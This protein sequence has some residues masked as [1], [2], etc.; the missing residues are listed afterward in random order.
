MWDLLPSD[1]ERM[2]AAAV[3]EYLEGELPLARLRPGAGPGDPAKA[4]QGMA[5]LGWFGVGLPE[6]VGGAGLGLVA[7]M[8]IQRECGRYLVSPTVL[9]TV[10]ASHVAFH[11]GDS[12]R[13]A[14][15]VAGK[16]PMALA[17][18]AEPA[19]QG[20][21]RE[22]TAFDWNAGEPLL[23]WNEDGMGLFEAGAF[24]TAEAGD[25]FDESISLHA[26]RLAPDEASLW[27]PAD[28]Q[29][30]LLRAQVLLAAAL[31]GLAEHACDLAVDY[32]RVREQFGKPIG[33]FQAI[34]QRCADM[35]V[36]QRLSWY[37]T[38]LA[39]LKLESAAA[40]TALQVASAKLLAAEAAHENG[41]A[42]IQVHGGIG[43]QA[44]CDAQWFLM[45]ARLFDQAGGA[46]AQQA[47]RIIAAPAP[48]W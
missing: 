21:K 14:E 4:W 12:A 23:Y 36:R 44:E 17:I 34:K 37:Q 40:D 45:R 15:L 28:V 31:V 24:G 6:A 5:E 48:A 18:D 41:R 19:R 46:I 38:S 29:P 16:S 32:A 11:A 47:R 42:C 8:L 13:A 35:A 2:I 30:L 22:V 9:A 10:L 26:G 27:V 3:R 33:S 7:E 25:C 1:D 39:C 43:F 20:A